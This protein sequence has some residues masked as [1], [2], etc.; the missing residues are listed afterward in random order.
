MTKI[1]CIILTLNEEP[2]IEEALKQFRR[3]V[4]FILVVDG[5]S[6]DKT[7]EIAKK[8][9]NKTVIHTF[10]G[11][12]AD[13]KNYARTLVPVDCDYLLW[14]DADERWDLGFLRRIEWR[15]DQF[16]SRYGCF[17]IPRIELPDPSKS[18]PDYQVRVFPNSRDIEWK[19]EIH[20]IPIYKPENIPLDQLDQEIRQKKLPVFTA[21]DYPI[22][23]LP[24]RTNGVKRPWWNKEKKE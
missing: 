2:R 9:A 6:T 19:G 12:F 5:E 4:N 8:Y 20:E 1:A 10:S 13:E 24:R 15:I 17:R 21:D 11:S 7:V 3:Y 16:P 23:H 18:Y 14:A 22:L